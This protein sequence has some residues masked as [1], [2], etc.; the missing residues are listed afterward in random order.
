MYVSE[1]V[2]HERNTDITYDVGSLRIKSFMITDPEVIKLNSCS[3]QL[4]IKFIL[5]INVK[6][7]TIVGI[8]TFMSRLNTISESSKARRSIFSAFWFIR[9]IEN[10]CSNQLSIKKVS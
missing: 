2:L 8:L 10:P 3:T 7:S 6:M 4:S 9:A 1:L 5:L